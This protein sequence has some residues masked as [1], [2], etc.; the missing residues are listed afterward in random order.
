MY[1]IGL[2]IGGT[3][4]AATLGAGGET[5]RILKKEQFLTKGL[6]P[7]SVLQRFSRFIDECLQ[8]YKVQGIGKGL[9]SDQSGCLHP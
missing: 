9:L 8:D 4:C 6:S 3:K 1:Y 5:I 7:Q 2:D